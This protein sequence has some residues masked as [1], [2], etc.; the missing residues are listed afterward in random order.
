MDYRITNDGSKTLFSSKYNQTFHSLQDG[1]LSE[2]LYKHIIP[3]FQLVE[4]KT[5]LN[6]LDICFGLGYNTFGTIYYIKENNLNI[7]V[8]FYSPELD[9]ELIESLINFEYP[10]E[11]DT[12]KEIIVSLAKEKCYKDNQFQINLFIGDAREYIKTLSN[13][14]IVYQDAFSSD[15]NHELW[16]KEYF[17]D[18]SKIAASD[19]IITTYSI[20]TPIRLAIYENNFDVYEYQSSIKKRSTIAFKEKIKSHHLINLK[21]IDMEKKKI[22]SPKAA[23]LRDLNLEIYK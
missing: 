3:A 13:I 16:T 23:P 20:A 5:K 4:N 18:I 10:K 17:S 1:A 11:F 12:I 9:D 21:Y 22:N 8:N 15:T 2:S 7:K 6:I 19:A 14:N